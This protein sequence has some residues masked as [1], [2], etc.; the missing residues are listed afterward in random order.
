M[1]I[2]GY[3]LLFLTMKIDQVAEAT[4]LWFSYSVYTYR[5]LIG[6][7]RNTKENMSLFHTFLLFLVGKSLQNEHCIPRSNS[8]ILNYLQSILSETVHAV[9]P[10]SVIFILLT[11]NLNHLAQK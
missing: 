10:V 3:H 5:T 9:K 2:M 6:S 1:L 11:Y 4:R 8:H 7:T